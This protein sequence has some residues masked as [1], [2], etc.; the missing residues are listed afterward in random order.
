MMPRS[1]RTYSGRTARAPPPGNPGRLRCVGH[2]ARFET[3]KVVLCDLMKGNLPTSRL[4]RP[5]SGTQQ[6][7]VVGWRQRIILPE[8]EYGECQFSKT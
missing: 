3:T 8:Q 7:F 6:A 4:V 5:K 1:R 2:P